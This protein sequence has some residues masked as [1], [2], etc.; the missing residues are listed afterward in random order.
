MN[1]QRMLVWLRVGFVAV[2][3]P[4]IFIL[5]EVPVRHF[6]I[7]VDIGAMHLLG[8]T[9]VPLVVR[10][11]ALVRPSHGSPFWVYLSPSCSSFASITTL[12]CLT[13][14]LPERVAS[15]KNRFLAFLVAAVAVFFG[16]LLRIDFSIG[17]GLVAG[18][19]VLVL[20]HNWA[21]SVFGFF[22]TMG[23]FIIMLWLLLPSK[24][25][26]ISE[27]MRE[28]IGRHRHPGVVTGPSAVAS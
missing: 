25:R 14:A 20:F 16:N 9:G 4:V 11:S 18:P 28:A 24:N 12:G 23:G 21:G 6:E 2:A 10:M 17:A 15:R 8:I 7:G 1:R 19:T 3:T 26:S 5:F 13:A 22:Y 27:R